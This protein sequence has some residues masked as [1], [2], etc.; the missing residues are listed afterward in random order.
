MSSAKVAI[1]GFGR[2]GRLVARAVQDTPGLELVAV[3]DLAPASSL[4]HL[5]K[6]DSVHGKYP[7]TVHVH[8]DE[9]VIDGDRVRVLQEKDPAQLPWQE[10]GV[11]YVIE[12]TGHFTDREDLQKHLR[13]GARRVILSAPGKDVDATLVLGVN[14]DT[15]DPQEH[16]MVSNASC[17]TNCLAPVLK[18]LH[19]TFGVE[20]GMMTTVHAYTND[21]RLLDTP[22]K[23]PRR[24][25]S[26]AHSFMPTS[27]GAARAIGQVLPELDRKIDG[28]AIRVPVPNVSLVDLNVELKRG[29]TQEEV[30]SAFRDAEEN[31]LQG[32]LRCET[33]PLV[34]WDFNHDPASAIVDLAE[35]MVTDD[36]FLK[37]L[38]WYDN[39][40]AYSMRTAQL[41]KK[42]AEL[43]K[44][45]TISHK[46]PQGRT[47]S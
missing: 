2:I 35:I 33:Q 39:E 18:V 9:L 8:E 46:I 11:D 20:R 44:E 21:Q 27:T 36:R 42:I 15:Y 47:R 17:T 37:V 31:H 4:A 26:A 22:H 6:H 38:A 3:N 12:C 28:I 43:D 24:A 14:D 10:L 34:S 25:R 23:D 40:W 29:V 16:L 13:A 41:V 45:R 1:N 32:I 5:F 30:A 19:D 7:G